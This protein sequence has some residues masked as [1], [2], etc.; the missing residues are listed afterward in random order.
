M[1][2]L[3]CSARTRHP[4][5]PSPHGLS[6]LM[7]RIQ[8]TLSVVALAVLLHWVV[9]PAGRS[10]H[11]ACSLHGLNSSSYALFSKRVV[12]PGGTL[13][14]VVHVADGLVTAV[15]PAE[16]APDGALDYTDAVISPVRPAPTPSL[17]TGADSALW[18]AG[19]GGRA[20][21]PERARPVRWPASTRVSMA[22]LMR[23]LP[24]QGRLGGL[25]HR[26]SGS[27][28]R[29]RDHGRG[30]AAEQLSDDHHQGDL[31]PKTGCHKGTVAG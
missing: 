22:S 3:E 2:R 21:S 11:P 16:A 18:L 4:L 17:C 6:P 19:T 9:D 24:A 15:T 26:H 28:R 8:Q 12:T 30:H 31:P 7:A 1:R 23:C 27:R 10:A 13:S 14:A 25:P 20:C 5:R 29:R